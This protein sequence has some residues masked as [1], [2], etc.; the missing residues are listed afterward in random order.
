MLSLVAFLKRWSMTYNALPPSWWIEVWD[1]LI[2]L[3][4]FQEFP[5]PFSQAPHAK[6]V[7]VSCPGSTILPADMLCG[8]FAFS[9]VLR[10]GSSHG[11]LCGFL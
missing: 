6:E 7:L 1:L 8:E 3:G 9:E 4:F 11:R 10:E 2:R 5:L